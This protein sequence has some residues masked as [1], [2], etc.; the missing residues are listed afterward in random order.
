MFKLSLASLG[1]FAW[2][3]WEKISIQYRKDKY[4]YEGQVQFLLRMFLL[5]LEVEA[6][7]N[8]HPRIIFRKNSLTYFNEALSTGWNCSH[9]SN[10]EW[11]ELGDSYLFFLPLHLIWTNIWE[12]SFNLS[13]WSFIELV[14]IALIYLMLSG[15]PWSFLSLFSPIIILFRWTCDLMA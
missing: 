2:V 4:L 14:R 10:V 15:R 5:R 8:L 7:W 9:L 11:V 3:S 1:A 12:I 13:G 6:Y